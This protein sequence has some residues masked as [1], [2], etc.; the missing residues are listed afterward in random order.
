MNI[1]RS[2]FAEE[3]VDAANYCSIF[4]HLHYLLA[5]AELRSKISDTNEGEEIGPFRLVQK[6][7]DAFKSDADFE[8]NFLSEDIH[9]WRAQ[10]HIFALI[11]HRAEAR[12]FAKLN[13][14]PSAVELYLEQWPQAQQGTLVKDLKDALAST[15]GLLDPAAKAFFGEEIKVVPTPDPSAPPTLPKGD[16]HPEFPN[17]PKGRED[18]AQ[19][20]LQMFKDAGFARH[21]Q[22]AALA[23]AIAES[24]LNPL[25]HAARGEDSWGLFQLNRRHGLGQGHDPS[26]LKVPEKNT[27]IVI[28]A[29]KQSK[30]FIQAASLEDA[31][32]A[33][34][35]EVECPRDVLG[36]CRVRVKIA[37]N[38]VA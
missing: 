17:V 29:A 13:R 33:F 37:H 3:C 22:I 9:R 21:Q 4:T 27:A 12:L 2:D 30:G 15:E 16:D 14:N 26:E 19:L 31:V 35:R 28:K 34:V 5:V 25:A 36:Q 24:G 6:D 10:C 23:N 1:D 32:T 38:L 20:I 7:W 8:F 11:T 18:I